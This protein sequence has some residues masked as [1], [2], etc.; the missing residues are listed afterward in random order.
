MT[1][2]EAKAKGII[3]VRLAKWTSPTCYLN[4]WHNFLWMLWD[5][6]T[7]ELIEVE[8]PQKILKPYVQDDDDWMEYTGSI[9]PED[10][11]GTNN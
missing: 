10:T 9:D 5:R 4:I 2:D 6:T 11:Y 1:L 7:Q 8:T 3:R